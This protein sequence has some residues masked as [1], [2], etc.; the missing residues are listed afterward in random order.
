MLIDKNSFVTIGYLIRMGEEEY[1][2]QSGQPEEISFCMGW[3]VMP[4][5]LEEALLGMEENEQ[6]VVRLTAAEAYGETDQEL[7]MEVPRGDFAP[8]VELNPGQV[9]E[10]EDEEGNPVYF[11]VQEVRPDSA[12]IDFNHPLAGRELEVSF[13]VHQVREATPEDLQ[14]QHS[15]VECE[16]GSHQ[17]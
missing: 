9:F 3:G 1:Y 13:T 8:E 14:Q 5:G 11:V 16:G 17:H 10:T 2:P 12:I 4:M 6:K 7:I 15:C